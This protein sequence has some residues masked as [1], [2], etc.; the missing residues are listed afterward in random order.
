M[1]L[2]CASIAAMSLRRSVQLPAAG[3]AVV[4]GTA[5]GVPAVAVLTGG[6]LTVGALVDGVGTLTLGPRVA[7]GGAVT[8]GLLVLGTGALTVGAPPVD[9]VLSPG[10]IASSFLAMPSSVLIDRRS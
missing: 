10:S 2:D 8:V 4:V 1:A 6:V 9:A 3:D 5:A 7:V